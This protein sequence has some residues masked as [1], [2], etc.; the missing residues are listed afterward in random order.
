MQTVYANIAANGNQ[1][2]SAQEQ[3]ERMTTFL[4]SSEAQV[5]PHDQLEQWLTAEGRELQRRLLQEHLDL[6]AGSERRLAAVRGADAVQ[7]EEARPLSRA[8]GT[9]FGSVTVWRL[10]Y[11]AE[12][13]ACLCP[14]DAGLNLPTELYSYGVRRLVALQAA[15]N[16]FNEVV[17]E[18][19]SVTGTAVHKRQVEELARAAAQDFDAFYA[20]RDPD[21]QGVSRK[22]VLV[23]TADG[24]GI[25]V[26]MEDLREAT[27][28][29]A[30][31]TNH[32]LQKRLTKGE[33]RNRKRM[34]EVAAVYL[35]EPF[36]RDAED[37]VRELR[38]LHDVKTRRPR[39]THKRV[40]ASVVQDAADVIDEAFQQAQRLDPTHEHRWVVVVDGNPDQIRAVLKIAARYRVKVTLILDVIHVL[41]YLWK[42]AYCFHPDASQEAEAWVTERLRALLTGHDPSQVAAGIRRSATRQQLSAAKREA[43]DSCARYLINK[44]KLLGYAEALRQGFPIASGVIEGACRYLVKDRMDRTGARWSLHGAEAVLRLRAIRTNGDFDDY[45]LF[46]LQQEYDRNHRARYAAGKVPSPLAVP[47]SAKPKLRRIK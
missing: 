47:S 13:V 26:R 14:L 3:F 8:L 33:K 10:G 45:W 44:R 37:V 7:R 24:K 42:A 39:P 20:Q 35:V 38:P 1:E 4:A 27:R 6:R 29:A 32:K 40:W 46:H 41:E 36:V 18:V 9:L 22:A 16:S 43:A 30:Q 2:H 12:G 31:N 25:V 34:A 17:E 19:E 15:R 5:L 11:Q 21:T 23:L 28:Q